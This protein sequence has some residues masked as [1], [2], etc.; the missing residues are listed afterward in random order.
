MAAAA[1]EYGILG[2]LTFSTDNMYFACQFSYSGW[3]SEDQVEVEIWNFNKGRPFLEF[4]DSDSQCGAESAKI[5]WT[6]DSTLKFQSINNSNYWICEKING[7]WKHSGKP[8]V[9]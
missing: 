8:M 1:E 5:N 3:S 6:T 2:N 4:S 7:R 9:D